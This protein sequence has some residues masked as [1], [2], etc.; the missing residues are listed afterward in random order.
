MNRLSTTGLLFLVVAALPFAADARQKSAPGKVRE[1]A[2]STD[3]KMKYSLESIQARPG[4][5]LKVVLKNAGTMPKTVMGHN[6]V[7]LQK[8]TDAPAFVRAGLT[9]RDTD[10]ISP[11]EKDKVIAATTMSGPGES[12]EVTFVAPTEPGTYEYVCTFPGHYASG[13]KGTLV[14]K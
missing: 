9:S 5:R 6:F 3:D 4:E 7:V 8:G 13:M 10:F 12:V 11:V 14:V 1:V 2:I